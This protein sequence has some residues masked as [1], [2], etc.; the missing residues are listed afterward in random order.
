MKKVDAKKN[1]LNS[2]FKKIVGLII[3]AI[4]LIVVLWLFFDKEQGT[5]SDDGNDFVP[6]PVRNFTNDTSLDSFVFEP[7]EINPENPVIQNPTKKGS[8][9][10]KPKLIDP[11]I[12]KPLD[13]LTFG[14]DS[15]GGVEYFVK[16]T[17]T[18]FVKN[19]SVDDEC[20]DNR[21]L[22]ELD[23]L[24]LENNAGE[25][26]SG[27]YWIELK[28]CFEL[29]NYG[30]L[31]GKC[32]EIVASDT[33]VKLYSLNPEGYNYKTKG[34]CTD[35]SGDYLEYCASEEILIEYGVIDNACFEFEV[36]C[37][38][39]CSDGACIENIISA[40]DSDG[41]DIYTEGTCIDSKG[42][43][44]DF[45]SSG[46]GINEWYLDGDECVVENSYCG[47]GFRCANGAC[48]SFE[49]EETDCSEEC[50]QL[51]YTGWDW[52]VDDE[53][54][55]RSMSS[56]DYAMTEWVED[57][58]CCYFVPYDEDWDGTS[59]NYTTKTKCYYDTEG[60]SYGDY[61]LDST[62]LAERTLLMDENGVAQGC[63]IIGINCQLEFGEDWFC[64]DGACVSY[65]SDGE[66]DCNGYCGFVGF[67]SGNLP[68]EGPCEFMTTY[69]QYECCCN[70]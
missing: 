16:G 15:D 64:D 52:D 57:E 40:S 47:D 41:N 27:C 55:C 12:E 1:L 31:D 5:G 45:C 14:F 20:A 60:S 34:T 43:H 8:T 54:V 49:L 24:A 19:Y 18:D 66:I 3:V 38:T 11:A 10:F 35:F 23:F 17:C 67:E 29:G 21:Y 48:V 62:A 28:D 25:L 70:E 50:D 36:Y 2:K 37:E 69:E 22:S 58:C 68:G 33:D 51:G 13:N 56:F 53:G 32:Q 6:R 65:V 61:C 39:G 44:D 63:H 59:D 30:C 7:Q 46:L 26:F 9:I 4:L 42:E